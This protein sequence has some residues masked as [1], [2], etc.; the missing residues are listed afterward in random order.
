WAPPTT[1]PSRSTDGRS[2]S[3]SATR[4]GEHAKP[5]RREGRPETG[6][7]GALARGRPSSS[8][9]RSSAARPRRATRAGCVRGSHGVWR[10]YGAPDFDDGSPRRGG[11][12]SL[13][14]GSR[15]GPLRLGPHSQ[16]SARRGS[17][18]LYRPP[19]ALDSPLRIDG[20][21]TR[22]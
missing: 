4:S 1:S 10:L 20:Q 18:L 12:S 3:G 22:G 14:E 5:T 15:G 8:I 2:S 19:P 13:A 11:R 16:G 17:P 9:A 21:Q 6:S 7:P